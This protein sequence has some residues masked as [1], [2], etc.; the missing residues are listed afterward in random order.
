[1]IVKVEHLYKSFKDMTIFEDF[2]MEVK[3]GTITIIN[4]PSG[5]GKSTLL[6]MI[7]LLDQPDKGT[8]TL[9]GETN[10]KP[11]SKRAEKLLRDKLGYLFQNFALVDDE[12]VEYNLLLA[13]ENSKHFN[14]KEEIKKALQKVGLQG[15]EKKKIYKCSG[16]EQQRVA[17]ARLL[18]KPCE[19]IL[20][21]EPTGSLDHDNKLEV[22]NLLKTLQ[23]MG[24]TIIIVTHDQELMDVGEQHIQLK[25][26]HANHPDIV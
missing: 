19:L 13:L 7:G 2:D 14:K 10:V 22:I 11:F 9:F 21:D 25:N 6:N 23:K 15:Y 12:S 4:G 17:I 24:K 5:C 26:L 3:K 1:M 8:I 18:L 20:A 16:G